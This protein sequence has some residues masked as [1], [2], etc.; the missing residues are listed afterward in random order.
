MATKAL[1]PR[2]PSVPKAI[3]PDQAE[4]LVAFFNLY[5]QVEA[6]A[7]AENTAEAKRRDLNGFLD[8]FTQAVVSDH[9]DH[10]TRSM[11][12][13]YRFTG[14]KPPLSPGNSESSAI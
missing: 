1:V 11:T 14:K 3:R 2:R 4:S 7:S 8:F 5:I 12:T 9:P 6:A 10:W 13:G